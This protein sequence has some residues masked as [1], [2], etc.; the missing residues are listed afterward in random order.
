MKRIVIALF[1][2]AFATTALA[3]DGAAV[4]AAKCKVCHGASGEG[5]KAA[6]EAIK[7]KAA[8]AT[9]K[10]V[11]EGKGK[12]KAVKLEAADAD[13]VAGFVAGMK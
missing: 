5:T 6:P 12:M 13:A 3:A 4:Y 10:A 11:V 2:V 8:D 7:G 9:K 1:A